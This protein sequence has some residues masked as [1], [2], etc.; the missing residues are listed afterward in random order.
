MDNELQLRFQTA[1]ALHQAGQL[2][3]AEALYRDILAQYPAHFGALHMLGVV[4]LTRHDAAIA[5]TLFD[6]ALVL[7]PHSADALYNRAL[8]QT[9]LGR[10]A[11]ALADYERAIAV[12]PA[13]YRAHNNRAQL[14]GELRRY[15][16]AIAS[17]E[18]AIALKPEYAE[19][20]CNRGN[21]QRHLAQWSAAVASYDRAI[22]LR[23]DLSAAH[24][25]RGA[26]LQ[27]LG[28]YAAALASHARALTLTPATA[29]VH[30]NRGA[31]L[32]VLGRHAEAVA[33]CDQALA[34]A[35]QHALAWAN[36]GAALFAL[37]EFAAAVASSDRAL[38]L[39]PDFVPAHSNRGA[40]L[41]E[42]AQFEA[43]LA[44]YDQAIAGPAE[45]AEVNW[46]KSLTLLLLGDFA[47]GWPLY[48]WRWQNPKTGCRR[49][50]LT[51]PEWRGEDVLDGRTILLYGEQGF[52]DT[53]QF[54]RYA[55]VLAE[56]GARVILEVRAPLVKL[57][58]TLAGVAEVVAAGSP[59]PA[60][61]YHCALLSLPL[62]CATSL[63]TI[64]AASSYLRAGADRIAV[65]RERLGA[66]SRP[67]IGLVWSGNPTH[68]NDRFRSLPLT[69][70]LP[71]LPLGCDYVSLQQ[72]LREGDREALA[73]RSDIR[74]FGA[75]LADFTD[76]AALCSLVDIV[77][78]VDTS[79]AHLSG[80]L[81][82]PTWL[83]L[84][85]VPDWR[86]LLARDDSPWYPSMRLC[87]QFA[88]A[89][90]TGVLTRVEADLTRLCGGQ[91]GAAV[92]L[93]TASAPAMTDGN[94][95]QAKFDRGLALHQAGKLAPAESLYR[96][97]L[98]C[99]PQHFDTWHMLGV[100]ALTQHDAAGACDLIG[101]AVAL[102]QG[103]SDAF[104][105]F[106][107]ALAAAARMEDALASYDQA[108]ALRPDNHRAYNNRANVL[109]ELS[110][111]DD[112]VI[113]C[114]RAIALK[115]D[116]A[117]AWCN[118]G[119][120]LR[121]LRRLHDALASY[122]RALAIRPAFVEAALNKAQTL[123]LAADFAGGWPLFEWR[124][125]DARVGGQERKL[126]GSRWRGEHAV[127]GMTILLYAEQ[128]QGDVI[129]FCRYASL[130]A[131]L[132]ARVVLEVGAPLVAVM[133][134][135]VGVAAVVTSGNPLPHFD[136]H[137][138]LLSLPL[139]FATTL[140]T[141]PASVGYLRATADKLASWR[142]R[143]GAP[144]RLRVGLVWSG[145][146]A[147]G[148]DRK[149]SL[150]V[151]Q[152]LAHL[153]TG[154]EYISLQREVR[155]GDRE[156]LTARADIRHFGTEL[157]DFSDT[158]AVCAL[159]DVIVSVDTSVAHLAGALGRSTWLLLPFIPD[160][161]WL[162]DRND[163]P[164]YPSMKIYRQPVR[165]DWAGVL[166]RVAAALCQLRDQHDR[167]IAAQ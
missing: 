123:L 16:D 116:Y 162:F 146:P 72:E 152:L 23:P 149:R 70:L 28:H 14:L 110:R 64:P 26:A 67:R 145:N 43:A 54:C 124:W 15:A 49:R 36:R 151:A 115:Q 87:R 4:A 51:A 10:R 53:L 35:P 97:V 34:L 98:A 128:G 20:Y 132:G 114:E 44:S 153:P 9:E 100:I 163:S 57:M 63:E 112:A 80:A 27:E 48:E 143:L 90:W 62:A 113:S 61:D 59:V 8:A 66:P 47:A 155:T 3:Q 42:L 13:H 2:T 129:Q 32:H 55:S 127:A 91:G 11:G 125:A 75:A 17:C 86:W 150:P 157:A 119:N 22:A 94:A 33:A 74:H 77:I 29:A 166:V 38:A 140:E 5:C 120:A 7:N 12:D 93:L 134:D 139:A 154:F 133:R 19:A 39:N 131:G 108:I 105:N 85:A 101:R 92:D 60:F 161:R 102:H 103:S 6:Q 95:A 160:W 45:H 144:A 165:D 99:Q 104:Y 69:C 52:G 136:Y 88:R 71:H 135:L 126:P 122:D 30:A 148:N 121:Q 81:G 73:T 147:H 46:N 31:T 164:W 78:S 25:N 156:A 137:C 107:L 76:T 89:D 106:G 138:P 56:R 158:A 68:K 58:H 1:V 96:E 50:D 130:V 141:I 111:Y 65:W 142:V 109:G 84:P 82:R 83:L 167:A 79:V 37:D 41:H 18:C 117:E 21:A 118:R 159:V 24:A 40:A